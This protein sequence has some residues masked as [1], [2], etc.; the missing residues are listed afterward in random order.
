MATVGFFNTAKK[1]VRKVTKPVDIRTGRFNANLGRTNANFDKAI[2][3]APMNGNAYVNSNGATVVEPSKRKAQ[4]ESRKKKIETMREQKRKGIQKKQM[5]VGLGGGLALGSAAAIAK[6][7]QE[8]Q[9]RP[10]NK[11]RNRFR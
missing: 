4:L 10:M 1:V 3:R 5:V 7:R 9:N 2:K 11:L 8:E 6:K